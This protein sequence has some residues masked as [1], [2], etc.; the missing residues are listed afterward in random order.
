MRILIQF[1]RKNNTQIKFLFVLC[2]PAAEGK[3]LAAAVV[4][5]ATICQIN[6][7]NEFAVR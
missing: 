5:A 6:G 2:Q 4:V 7:A 1:Q 3:C